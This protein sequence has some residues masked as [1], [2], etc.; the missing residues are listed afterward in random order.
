MC[1]DTFSQPQALARLAQAPPVTLIQSYYECHLTLQTALM[2]SIGN[3]VATAGLYVGLIWIVLGIMYSQILKRY[4]RRKNPN[5]LLL[6]D[7]LRTDLDHAQGT[8]RLELI[9]EGLTRMG[10]ELAN[11]QR[12]LNVQ[13]QSQD[14]RVRLKRLKAL[15]F[16]LRGEP[17]QNDLEKIAYCGAELSNR[18]HADQARSELPDEEETEKDQGLT[19]DFVANEA[20]H[21]K[22]SQRGAADEGAALALSKQQRSSVR[23]S[24]GGGHHSPASVVLSSMQ[25]PSASTGRRQSSSR[26]I[27]LSGRDITRDREQGADFHQL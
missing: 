20:F 11:L 24:V 2:A 1:I 5:A 14:Y 10:S 23:L 18:L 8:L 16:E 13:P 26:G 27:F 4:R 12:A 9:Y 3:A 6:T 22:M 7:E 25:P 15:F 19:T 21:R 17:S